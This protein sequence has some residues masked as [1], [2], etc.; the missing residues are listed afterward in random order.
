MHKKIFFLTTFLF[1][2]HSF[3]AATLPEQNT[4]YFKAL[5]VSKLLAEA[6]KSEQMQYNAFKL[7]NATT[8][9]LY[10]FISKE[11]IYPWY[12]SLPKEEQINFKKFF[13]KTY[14][15]NLPQFFNQFNL[16]TF[17]EQLAISF[18]DKHSYELKNC[19]DFKKATEIIFTILPDIAHTL[20]KYQLPKAIL[21]LQ[22]KL[23][24]T[25]IPKNMTKN[26]IFNLW[27]N[28]IKNYLAS[29][30]NEKQEQLNPNS[31]EYRFLKEATVKYFKPLIQQKLLS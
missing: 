28:H 14:N 6:I 18:Q 8:V 15:M 16:E 20:Q 19:R 22:E 13:E 29:L 30:K 3:F 12:K 2:K 25:S 31:V 26:Q 17:Q 4:E 9:T 7:E 21:Q 24:T 27:I 5:I 1:F 10:N 23:K 11:N